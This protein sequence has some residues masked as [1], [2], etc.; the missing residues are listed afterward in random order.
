MHYNIAE[1]EGMHEFAA[2]SCAITG[3]LSM[4]VNL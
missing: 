2:L 3:I 4:Q 1:K